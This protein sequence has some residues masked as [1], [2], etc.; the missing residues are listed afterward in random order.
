MLADAGLFLDRADLL[1]EIT[2][3]CSPRLAAAAHGKDGSVLDVFE[4]ERETAVTGD[5]ENH[6]VEDSGGGL[7][8]A[9][10]RQLVDAVRIEAEEGQQDDRREQGF[11][12]HAD[13]PQK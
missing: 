4:G 12:E 2:L 10:R 8:P 13:D 5:E 3:E 1:A 7:H 11:F 6:A 9:D